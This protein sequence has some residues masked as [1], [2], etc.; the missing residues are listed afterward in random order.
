MASEEALKLL[1]TFASGS[2]ATALIGPPIKNHFERRH[3]KAEQRKSRWAPLRTTARKLEERF[4]DL[5]SI[6]LKQPPKEPWSGH[7]W[8]EK[9][10]NILPSKA[11]DFC[12]LYLLD[13]DPLPIRNWYDKKRSSP[14]DVRKD[15]DKID[16]MWMRFHEMTYAASSLHTTAEYLAYAERVREE[17]ADG[18]LVVST[19]VQRRMGDLL[20]NVRR[21]LHGISQDHP[22]AGIVYEHQELIG[23]NMWKDHDTVIDLWEFYGKLFSREWAQ[24]T[25]LFRFFIDF[26][27]KVRTEVANTKQAL[28]Q[29]WKEIETVFPQLSR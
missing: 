24:F 11:R 29:L 2:V 4:E 10:D 17:L 3:L 16:M 20:L 26:H 27:Y 13:Q 8:S 9:S 23:K 28:G 5:T 19:R 14:N 18:R 21:E 6:Y 12:E 15:P 25:D 7:K 22:G 1:V